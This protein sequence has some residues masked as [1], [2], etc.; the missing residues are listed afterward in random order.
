MKSN[1][2]LVVGCIFSLGGGGHGLEVELVFV[3][4]GEGFRGGFGG[5]LGAGFL[6]GF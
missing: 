2:A 5:G 4:G 1:L 6:R 3:T